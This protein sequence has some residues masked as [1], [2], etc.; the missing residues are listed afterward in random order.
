[1]SKQVEV[2]WAVL[3]DDAEWENRRADRAP[4]EGKPMA[5]GRVLSRRLIRSVF[6][7]SFLLLLVA[8]LLLWQRAQA[9]LAETEA[10][11]SAVVALEGIAYTSGN[12]RLIQTVLDPAADGEWRQRLLWVAV[13]PNAGR[14]ESYTIERMDLLGEWALVRLEMV[15]ADLPLAYR[16]TRF[17]R[18]GA[19]GWRHT[20][21]VAAFWGDSESLESKHFVFHFGSQDR[22]AVAEVA[23]QLDGVWARLLTDF[24]LDEEVGDDKIVVEIV[25]G[26]GDSAY[27][28]GPDAPLQVSS[29][30]FLPLPTEATDG[31]ALLQSL[32]LPLTEWAVLQALAQT[33]SAPGWALSADVY[34]GLHLWAVWQGGTLLAAQRAALVGWRFSS[35]TEMS[36]PD[37]AERTLCQWYRSWA[38]RYWQRTGLKCDSLDR[39]LQLVASAHLDDLVFGYDRVSAAYAGTANPTD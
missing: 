18:D 13:K 33:P 7:A 36:T 10:E 38:A 3:L 37:S 21:P 32:L 6:L 31:E 4:F 26:D 9:G 25:V 23:D 11:L 8:T 29:P 19:S 2:V 16:E 20:A 28:L 1:M 15:R 22:L 30:L 14:E 24:G 39:P 5:S 34:D 27:W 35:Q 17:Y 12:A